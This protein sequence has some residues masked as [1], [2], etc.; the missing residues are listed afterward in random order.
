MI[1]ECGCPMEQ[2]ILDGSERGGCA[3]CEDCDQFFPDSED[4][5]DEEAGE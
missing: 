2:H 3:A 1:C 5:Q 4:L